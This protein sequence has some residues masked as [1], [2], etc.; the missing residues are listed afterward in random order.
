MFDMPF[1][2]SAALRLGQRPL[3]VLVVEDCAAQRRLLTRLLERGRA[4]V[5]R[6]ILAAPTAE[7]ALFIAEEFVPHAVLCDMELP[8]ACGVAF[9]TALRKRLP[10]ALVVLMSASP[11]AALKDAGIAA[12]AHAFLAKSNV[13]DDFE[14]LLADL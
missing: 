8:G 4:G 7:E 14:R 11:S 6:R 12:G 5:G 13:V 1:A 3:R 10:D 2:A 9:A